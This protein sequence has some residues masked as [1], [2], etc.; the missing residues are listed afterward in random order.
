MT[1]CAQPA[2]ASSS[3]PASSKRCCWLRGL[4][5]WARREGLVKE[6]GLRGLGGDVLPHKPGHGEG[7]GERQRECFT[8]LTAT[9][10]TFG[11]GWGGGGR[12]R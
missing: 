12:T 8:E 11:A 5:G 4:G 7:F 3:Q 2:A 9:F 6:E 10:K 1:K